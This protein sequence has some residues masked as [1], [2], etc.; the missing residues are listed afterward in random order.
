MAR[1]KDRVVFVVACVVVFGAAAWLAVCG[2]QTPA[3]EVPPPMVASS[4]SARRDLFSNLGMRS[5]ADGV[6]RVHRA[7]PNGPA[8]EDAG[9]SVGTAP[10]PPPFEAPQ[11]ESEW[12][13]E[14]DLHGK[15]IGAVEIDAGA[16]KLRGRVDGK[17]QWAYP[18]DADARR[19]DRL[20]LTLDLVAT[21]D[22]ERPT[23]V[24]REGFAAAAASARSLAQRLGATAIVDEPARAAA[25][26]E[27]AIALLD[28]LPKAEYVTIVLVPKSGARFEAKA[29]W[30]AV[31]SAGFEW[32]DGDYFH[33]LPSVDTDVSQGIWIADHDDG[34]FLPET[35]ADVGE[36]RLY[37]NVARVW[38]PTKVFEVMARAATYI[39]SRLGAASFDASA[40]R[41]R[42]A[43]TEATMR[44]YGV[45]PG[46][47]L[48][49]G[50]YP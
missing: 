2:L 8:T 11:K 37:F 12:I 32:G 15:T 31:Y 5:H 39:A 16:M 46:S 29:V 49:F 24:P 33:W 7:F 22:E 30:D 6:E 9:A 27:R 13:A 47:K 50:F 3:P 35:L 1:R 28:A 17:D 40:Q 26:S 48:A 42:V 23:A 10:A 44:S 14:L 19:F 36:L 4:A 34:Y 18:K 41:A 21:R 45:V 25:R 43:K 38:E 20:A